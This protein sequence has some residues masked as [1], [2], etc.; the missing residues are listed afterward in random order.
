M[1]ASQYFFSPFLS[2][3]IG[4]D[5][6]GDGRAPLVPSSFFPSL[7]SIIIIFL[8]FFGS[9]HSVIGKEQ[10]GI[11]RGSAAGEE[12]CE[13]GK[14]TRKGLICGVEYS[15]LSNQ[16]TMIYTVLPFHTSFKTKFLSFHTPFETMVLPFHTPF[17]TKFLPFHTPK[18]CT[19][20]AEQERDPFTDLR[21][22]QQF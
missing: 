20:E 12:E 2:G 10:G 6:E 3:K 18:N 8:F 21:R 4:G 16:C 11:I 5:V 7:D 15:I 13:M 19:W 14:K 1:K 17:D 22:L 9:I